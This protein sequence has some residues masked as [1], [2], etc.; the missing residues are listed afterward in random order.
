MKKCHILFTL[1]NS[2]Y[3]MIFNILNGCNYTFLVLNI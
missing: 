1:Y 2:F 3:N